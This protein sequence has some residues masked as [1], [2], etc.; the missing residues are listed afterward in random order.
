[1][2]K[3]IL[4]IPFFLAVAIFAKAQT[5]FYNLD[6]IQ[7]IEITFAQ[8]N[9]DYQMDTARLGQD[10][11]LM[12]ALLK[13]NGIAFDSVAVR[14]KGNSSYDSTYIKNPL[15]ISL[16]DFKS[17]DYHGISTIKLSNAYNDPSMIREVLSYK[18][19]G[20]YMDAP[21]ANFAQVYINGRYIGLY[22]NTETI[23]KSFCKKY[24]GSS[25]G[26]FIKGNPIVT[27]S[28]ITKCN[29]KYKSGMDST[30][31]FNFYEMKSAT[32][33]NELVALTDTVTNYPNSIGSILDMDRVIWMLAF[34]N[35]LVNLDSY[36][37][38]FCQNYYLYKD[39]NKRF[40]PVVWDL[41]MSLGGFP[42]LGSGA[43]STGQ[44]SPTT[45]QQLPLTAHSTDAYWPLIKAVM[46]NPSYRKMYMAH[47]KT[48]TTEMFNSH[49]YETQATAYQALIDTAV[50]HD[51]NKFFSYSQFQTGMTANTTIGS[52]TVPGIKTLV[53]ARATYLNATTDFNYAQP[54][55]TNTGVSGGIGIIGGLATIN[56]TVSNATS[57]FVK[58][59]AN[60]YGKFVATELYDDGAH[61]DGAAGDG[62]YGND[63]LIQSANNE[64][65]IY[66]ENAN[67]AK[68]A[69]EGAEHE[70]YS[71]AAATVA[72]TDFS[73][74]KN[75]LQVFP[76]PATAHIDVIAP[77]STLGKRCKL[78]N[79][80]G[81]IV[82]EVAVSTTTS[83]DVSELPN[84]LYFLTIDGF[85]AK[86]VVAK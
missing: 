8:P 28:P 65:Y 46:A 21:R 19:L 57:V 81:Q 38:V 78:S 83:F 15:N 13:I 2:K 63:V 86:V 37:G 42:F 12:A 4:L 45:M 48:I 26:V 31:Y 22:T 44:L 67:A 36:M 17:Q 27:P 85:N 16:D 40:N 70:F 73:T 39:Q 74:S 82:S 64:Y 69:P 80:L 7:K 84:G 24:F 54:V 76:N 5:N 6:T 9:W 58:V 35:V 41:N 3:N 30:A 1:M 60:Y 66:A 43:T 47:A 18:I 75:K 53:D 50:L 52:Y 29:L 32:G 20:N 55:I 62:V 79:Q 49:L 56:T 51:A 77:P 23:G 34:D 59:R 33:W 25:K 11:T 14:Y 10:G 72:T 71:F 61:N 68:F